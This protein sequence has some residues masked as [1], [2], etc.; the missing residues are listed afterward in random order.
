MIGSGD[1]LELCLDPILAQTE[2]S[3]DAPFLA[4]VLPIVPAQPVPA[5]VALPGGGVAA[6][7]GVGVG[8]AGALVLPVPLS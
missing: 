4:P 3:P 1:P 8:G 6:G 7:L 5:P 2:F